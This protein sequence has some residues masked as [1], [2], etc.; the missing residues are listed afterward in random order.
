MFMSSLPQIDQARR[1]LRLIRGIPASDGAGIS[2]NRVIGTT[3]LPDADPFLLFDELRC[4]DAKAYTE[5]FPSQPYRGFEA[6]TYM[7][8]G[9]LRH[10]D[11]KGHDGLIGPGGVQWLTAASGLMQTEM[12]VPQDGALQGFQIWLNLPASEKRLAPAYR[13]FAAR[14]IPAV[15]FE[16]AEVRLLAGQFHG[17]LGPVTPPSTQPFIVDVILGD[18]GEISLPIPEG[19]EG[20]VYVFKG[21]VAIERTLVNAGQAGFLSSGSRLD[22][23]AGQMGARALVVTARPIGEPVVRHGPFVMNTQAEIKQAF[24]DYQNGLF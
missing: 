9:R 1:V 14:D 6:I 19:N 12:P 22:L 7:V 10:N 24:T 3:G 4:E 2:L 16:Q 20:F 21:G 13:D 15:I 8:A 18:E 17:L 23:V 5:G 11:N